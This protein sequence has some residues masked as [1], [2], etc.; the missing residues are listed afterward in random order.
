MVKK[1]EK[2]PSGEVVSGTCGPVLP[3]NCWTV[4]DVTLDDH[5]T[6]SGL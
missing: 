5:F 3:V 2:I 6:I 1:R 4:K